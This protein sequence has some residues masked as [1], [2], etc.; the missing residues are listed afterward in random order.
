MIKY[1]LF[2]ISFSLI[3]CVAIKPT[4]EQAN[5][6]TF[7]Y[8]AQSQFGENYATLKNSDASHLIVFR[9]YKKIED[10]MASVKFFI[11]EIE[12]ESIIFQ[13]ELSS[14]TVKWSSKDEVIAISRNQ[15]NDPNK[16]QPSTSIYY[17]NVRSNVKKM[18]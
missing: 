8:L 9:K 2:I 15:N 12:S 11:Y 6:D 1:F 5:Q 16:K 3:S 14:G 17:Y 18:K 7:K 10:L 4:Q 13:D